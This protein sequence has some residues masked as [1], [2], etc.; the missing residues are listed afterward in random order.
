MY[1]CPD[2]EEEY[3]NDLS[4]SGYGVC[5]SGVALEGNVKSVNLAVA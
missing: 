2:I 5:I 4:V 3:L 1:H